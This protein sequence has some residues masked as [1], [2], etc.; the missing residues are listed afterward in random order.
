MI[1][2]ARISDLCCVS[3]SR[4]QAGESDCLPEIRGGKHS[5]SD[6]WMPQLLK[7]RHIRKV[8]AVYYIRC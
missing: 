7:I 2:F 5:L 1:S 6:I 3:L 4:F 8:R